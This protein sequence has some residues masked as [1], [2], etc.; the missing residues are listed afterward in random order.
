MKNYS[1]EYSYTED[2]NI[3]KYINYDQDI[4]LSLTLKRFKKNKWK[5]LWDYKQL[6]FI[7]I[8]LWE[9]DKVIKL[10]RIAL[11]IMKNHRIERIWV[12]A[13]LSKIVQAYIY[14]WELNKADY[15]INE[16][17]N[18]NM[19]FEKY[20]LEYRKWNY[21]FLIDNQDNIWNDKRHYVWFELL[22]LAKSYFKIWLIKDS[23]RIYKKMYKYGKQLEN[24]HTLLATYYCYISTLNLIWLYENHINNKIFKGLNK[25][26]YKYNNKFY[27]N[28]IENEGI[29]K[30]IDWYNW[31]YYNKKLMYFNIERFNH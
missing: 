25:I 15:I 6:M 16:Y 29:I 26:Y 12:H 3:K 17:S 28:R 20:M 23:I 4:A 11:N 18:I 13:I 2:M 14:I 22:F 7:Y 30:S 21:L 31:W 19:F 27:K 24:E 8:D 5:D 10:W 1:S 9:Y